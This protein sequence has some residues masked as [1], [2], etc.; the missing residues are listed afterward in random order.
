MADLGSTPALYAAQPTIMI[1][2]QNDPDLSDEIITLLVEEKTTGLY[3]CEATFN[4]LGSRS[5]GADFLFFDRDIL[6][7]GKSFAVRAGGGDSE[8]EIFSGRIMALEAHYPVNSSSE[9]VV[10]A[11][12]RFQDL[13]MTRR[14]RIFEQ[15]SDRDVIGEV[16]RHYNL[17]TDI[18]IDG[19][20]YPVVAQLNQSDLAFIRERARAVDAE[21][22]LEGETLHAQARGR[23]EAERVTLTYQ[24]GL[25]ELS[26]LA[27]LAHQRS[28]VTVSGWD[29]TAKEA[30][31][32]ETGESAIQAELNGH[33][34]GGSIL[35]RAIG[36]R[37]EHIVH[38]APFTSEEARQLAEAHYRTAARRFV[39]GQGICNGDGRIRVGG[40]IT[41]RGVGP[42]FK[43]EYYVT[44]VR[45]MFDGLNG[46][47]TRFSIERPGIGAN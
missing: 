16:A 3:R 43:G 41:L 34:G 2:G 22:W 5:S 11:E 10:L 18:D 23:R 30:I 36:S 17:Q 21:V 29:V 47:R 4:N 19:P 37:N 20:T 31:V 44:A 28:E 42:L 8:A 38:H 45:H 1:D 46:Y 27:D 33:I 32:S 13:R 24:Q 9:I 25:L 40:R 39:S 15:A 6:E 14:T 35:S 12:D 26:I 7:F